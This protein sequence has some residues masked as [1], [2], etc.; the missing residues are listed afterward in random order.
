MQRKSNKTQE[1]TRPAEKKHGG[2]GTATKA[3][4][5]RKTANQLSMMDGARGLQDGPLAA[6]CHIYILRKGVYAA[7]LFLLPRGEAQ[8]SA[9]AALKGP[10]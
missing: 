4:E 6:A 1:P 3:A 9:I 2:S 8:L 5:S 10:K 7:I